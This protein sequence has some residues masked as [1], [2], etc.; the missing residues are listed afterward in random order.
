MAFRWTGWL[1][2]LGL[3]GER[4]GTTETSLGKRTSGNYYNSNRDQDKEGLK[5]ES[6][7]QFEA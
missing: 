2:P 6:D 3:K 7:I 4:S 5:N 1:I